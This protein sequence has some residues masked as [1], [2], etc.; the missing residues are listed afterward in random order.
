MTIKQN[1]LAALALTTIFA[2]LAFL[3]PYKLVEWWF[4]FPVPALQFWQV[5]LL[6][7]ISVL[8]YA[9]ALIITNRMTIM[10]ITTTKTGGSIDE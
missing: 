3:L 8:L 4:G 6:G 7:N 10:V 5:V 1:R 9:L 2:G